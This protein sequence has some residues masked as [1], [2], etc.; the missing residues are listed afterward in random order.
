M[1]DNLR[2]GYIHPLRQ[3]T[4]LTQQNQRQTESD[5]Q[6]NSQLEFSRKCAPR[7]GD[8]PLGA[9]K[10]YRL[11]DPLILFR[12]DILFRLHIVGLRVA[13]V[14]M[15]GFENMARVHMAPVHSVRAALTHMVMVATV[16]VRR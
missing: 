9:Q 15:I 13:A 16:P 6:T 4:D 5:P 11:D 10:P 14:H 1:V 3:K 8:Q 2:K 12:F 7:S